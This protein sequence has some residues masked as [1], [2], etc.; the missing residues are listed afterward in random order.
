MTGSGRMPG[1]LRVSV[2]SLSRLTVDVHGESYVVLERVP[3]RGPGPREYRCQPLG[4]AVQILDATAFAR[5]AARFDFDSLRSQAEA[6]CRILVNPADWPRVRDFCVRELETGGRIL[7][8]SPDR[9]L[10]EELSDALQSPVDPSMLSS[11][12]IGTWV[13]DDAVTTENRRA[14]GLPTV[15]VYRIWSSLVCDRRLLERIE[16][17]CFGG[18]RDSRGSEPFGDHADE[19]RA[20]RDPRETA[21]AGLAAIPIDVLR[22]ACAES[23]GALSSQVVM[24][25]SL[26]E[27]VGVLFSAE[28]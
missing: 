7:E 11:R 12:A 15:R 13:R 24:G 9:E 1:Q 26:D 3:A 18:S 20:L 10:V 25:Q 2:A 5:G 16:H 23:E 17:L 14:A 8:S 27:T 19:P 22:A 28:K 4:G 21:A 6:D